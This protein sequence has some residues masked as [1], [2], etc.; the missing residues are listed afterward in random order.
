MVDPLCYEPG[1]YAFDA[2]YLRPQ[3]AAIYLIV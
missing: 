1:I 3:L 2:G